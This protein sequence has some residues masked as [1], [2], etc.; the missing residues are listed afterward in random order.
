MSNEKIEEHFGQNGIK[1][2]KIIQRFSI[3]LGLE[4]DWNRQ[5]IIPMANIDGSEDV[6]IE[7]EDICRDLQDL[8]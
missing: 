5:L 6:V 7:F 3:D 2:F 4:E 8:L 1:S